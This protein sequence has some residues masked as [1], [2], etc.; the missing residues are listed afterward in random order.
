M[1]NKFI[2]GI[3]FICVMSFIFPMMIAAE[4]QEIT[5]DLREKKTN[6]QF[7]IT[8]DDNDFEVTMVLPDGTEV[9]HNEFDGE[10]Y[11]YFSLENKR[12]WAVNKAAKGTYTFVIHSDSDERYRIQGKDSTKKPEIK[13]QKPLDATMPIKADEKIK[14]T[15]EAKGDFESSYSDM[16]IMLKPKDGWHKF[17]VDTTDVGKESYE[18]NLPES[19]PSGQYDLS[20]MI[21][22]AFVDETEIDPE[23]IIEYDN[24]DYEFDDI[25][26][27]DQIVENGM[28]YLIIEVPK[29][30]HF[31]QLEA[32]FQKKGEDEQYTA[33]V[34]WDELDAYKQLEDTEQFLWAV[35]TFETSGD[36]E[37]DVLAFVN[38]ETFSE[39]INL[40]PFHV[41]HMDYDE[42]DIE[43]SLEEGLTNAVSLEVTV[44]VS[45]D[46]VVTIEDGGDILAQKEVTE[47][48]TVI[49]APLDEGH[50]VIEVTVTDGDQNSRTFTRNF[51]VDH[52]P[53]S[54]EMI[55]PL[56]SHDTLEESFA[57]GFVE[58]DSTLIVNGN[59]VDYDEETGY[60]R[61]DDI[62]NSITIKLTDQSGNEVNY[63]WSANSTNES[64]SNLLWIILIN[65]IIVACVAGIIFYLR[66]TN[67]PS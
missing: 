15:W 51:Q 24:P 16:K 53:P 52:T 17:E 23:V 55:Q 20:I 33:S 65:V 59:E 11:M 39:T 25:E 32:R 60:F 58:Q 21:D 41:E 54:L 26:I 1:K 5:Y 46:S 36:Y 67:K 27:K 22:D 43:W 9:D 42:D 47:E 14:L 30:T 38:D 4:E 6:H 8:G 34:D 48:G 18:F 3:A 66:K 28:L 49:S 10:K 40:D 61:V 29:Y 50:R 63:T 35:T 64:E 57:S 56:T 7:I 31:E 12:I 44:N 62:K 45:D 2:I 13:W 37:G 19:I